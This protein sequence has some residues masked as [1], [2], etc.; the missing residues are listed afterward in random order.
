MAGE[1]VPFPFLTLPGVRPSTFRVG[2]V[3]TPGTDPR[4]DQNGELYGVRNEFD[5]TAFQDKGASDIRNGGRSCHVEVLRAIND[6]VFA[7]GGG[8]VKFPE[9]R[10][11]WNT[12]T[13]SDGIAAV[14]SRTS[15]LGIKGAGMQTRI[16]PR[17]GTVDTICQFQNI[18]QVK[19]EDF[20]VEGE[21]SPSPATNCLNLFKTGNCWRT[22]V[23]NVQLYGIK[24]FEPGGT[25]GGLFNVDGRLTLEDVYFGGCV[26]IYGGVVY[27]VGCQGFQAR[28]TFCLDYANTDGLFW[29]KTGSSGSGEA[30]FYFEKMPLMDNA[31]K[32]GQLRFEQVWCDEG[33]RRHVWVRGLIPDASY[34]K[35]QSLSVR[36]WGGNG[37]SQHTASAAGFDVENCFSVSIEDAWCGYSNITVPAIPAVTLKGVDYAELRNI[38]F[39]STKGLRTI[40]TDAN[41]KVMRT[42]NLRNPLYEL[43][44][45]TKHIQ[46]GDNGTLDHPSIRSRVFYLGAPTGH[47]P[48][49]RLTVEDVTGKIKAEPRHAGKDSPI[50]AMLTNH[51]S[52]GEAAGQVRV[53]NVSGVGMSENAGLVNPIAAAVGNGADIVA[54]NNRALWNTDGTLASIVKSNKTW[55]GAAHVMLRSKTASRHIVTKWR[56][57]GNFEYSVQYVQPFD[58]ICFVTGAGIIAQANAFGSPPINVPFWINW[59]YVHHATDPAQR[60]AYIR[61]NEGVWNSINVAGGTDTGN[62]TGRLA[63]GQS[64][65]SS[66]SFWDGWIDEVMFGDGEPTDAQ[67]AEIRTAP[68]PLEVGVGR[69]YSGESVAEATALPT[70]THS[71]PIYKTDDTI[72]CWLEGKARP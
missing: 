57:V 35:F 46:E 48:G 6:G 63:I 22:D 40:R 62:N 24:S 23:R 58:R 13:L 70:K 17:M 42:A 56:N 16:L 45:N 14:L 68:W 8:W 27:M 67:L 33:C 19:F 50:K 7:K 64:G 1:G 72:L 54:A 37:N 69:L 9:G 43:H 28:N 55:F 18:A 44:A 25:R 38:E 61:V 32:G 47:T 59:K 65:G 60:M 10:F 39:Q 66:T 15:F 3:Y 5:I 31:A 21:P 26:A 52:L 51:W 11:L 12:T 53:D 49:Y 29:T 41:C 20:A 30:W 34:A 36:G 4:L 71:I 2:D